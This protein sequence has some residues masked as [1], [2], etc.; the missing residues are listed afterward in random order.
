MCRAWSG[1]RVVCCVAEIALRR[2]GC[3]EQNGSEDGG[4]VWGAWM[5]RREGPDEV[6]GIVT[7]RCDTSR[8]AAEQLLGYCR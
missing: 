4:D 2:A 8:K 3:G 1:N 6:D 7:K 5:D